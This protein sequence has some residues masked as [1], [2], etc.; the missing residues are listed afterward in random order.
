MASKLQGLKVL[1]TPYK[2]IAHHEIRTD[3][4]V[5]ETPL[6]GKRP[7]IVR[8]HGGGLVMGDSLYL[9]FYPQWLTDLALA[10]GAIIIS[11][12][13][14]LLPEATTPQIFQDVAD[15]WAYIH[16]PSLAS[17]LSSQSPP[18][19]ADLARVLVTGDSAGGLLCLSTALTYPR[20]MRVAV[21]T[22]P[23]VD[24]GAPEFTRPRENPPLGK[25][26]PE[27]VYDDALAA[28]RGR[29][30]ESS[31]TSAARL[32]FM[33]AATQHGRLGGLVY[34]PPEALAAEGVR[35]PVGGVT[36]L[37]GR[38]D[39]VVPVESVRRFVKR[40]R[41]VVGDEGVRLTETDGEHGFDVALRY[42]GWLKGELK[43]AVDAWLE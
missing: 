20:D 2:T 9:P 29:P 21:A 25:S 4:L 34:F 7:V 32:D 17:L 10:H 38:D 33:L 24:P 12:N 41:E 15:F 43:R 28:A 31:V 11:P 6:S 27:S 22:Y 30:A 18:V 40:A 14:R 42:D 3:V 19:E 16:S 36:I 35:L 1:Q 5:P 8:F 26:V 39:S 13:Y 23:L 37:Q